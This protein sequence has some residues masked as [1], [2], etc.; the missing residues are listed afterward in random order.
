MGAHLVCAGL[1]SATLGASALADVAA[2]ALPAVVRVQAATDAGGTSGSGFVVDPF[3]RIVTSYH[4][5]DLATSIT[6]RLPSGVAFADVTVR[7]ADPASDL[8]LLEVPGFGLPTLMLGSSESLRPGDPVALLRGPGEAAAPVS[9]GKVRGRKRLE[10]G[11][12]VIETDA[13]AEPGA[14]GAPLIGA[15]GRVVG[16]LAFRVKWSRRSQLVVPVERV[17]ELLARARRTPP[18]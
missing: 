8:A 17:F 15:D 11:L 14:S 2:R 18:R 1:V 4:V 5:V 3:G 13:R 12:R 6:V 7:A 16:V 10:G 9:P